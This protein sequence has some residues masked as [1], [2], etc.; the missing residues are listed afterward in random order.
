MKKIICNSA[1]TVLLVFTSSQSFGS[2]QIDCAIQPT[3][4]TY[5]T[6]ATDEEKATTEAA[7][8]LFKHFCSK[9]GGMSSSGGAILQTGEQENF[10]NISSN[11]PPSNNSNPYYF[12]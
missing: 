1:I 4:L 11:P 9:T 6:A 5:M 10:I 7:L 2:V 12:H 8:P 3:V